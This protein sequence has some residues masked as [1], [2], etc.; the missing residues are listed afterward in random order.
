MGGGWN[1]STVF[2]PHKSTVTSGKMSF[3]LALSL[4]ALQIREYLISLDPKNLAHL[5]KIQQSL[6]VVS[7]DDSS[8]HATPE[9]YTEVAKDF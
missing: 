1:T 5:E 4:L 7:L 6:F 2:F 9:D 3:H 8:P